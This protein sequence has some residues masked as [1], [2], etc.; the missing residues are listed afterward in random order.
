MLGVRG[1]RGCSRS[2]LRGR[3]GCSCSVSVADVS[4]AHQLLRGRR[5][6]NCST[7]VL[8]VHGRRGCSC[9]VAK[10]IRPIS[11]QPLIMNE[12]N[13][14]AEGL[15]FQSTP[16]RPIS[17]RLMQLCFVATDKT[18]PRLAWRSATTAPSGGIGVAIARPEACSSL[19]GCAARQSHRAHLHP[20]AA[21]QGRARDRR[22]VARCSGA[23]LQSASRSASDT[24]RYL[25]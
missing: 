21:A 12:E 7:P 5:G 24:P 1:R 14:R 8:L 4:V 23:T 16:A 19:D 6:C 13:R 25:A 10:V 9:S 22:D 11:P 17:P 15:T 18:R 2:A 20:H 3:R